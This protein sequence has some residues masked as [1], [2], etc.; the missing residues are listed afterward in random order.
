MR[1]ALILATKSSDL[2]QVRT[3]VAKPQQQAEIDCCSRALT[4][5]LGAVLLFQM[6]AH[7]FG[8]VQ[9]PFKVKA[10]QHITGVRS[11]QRRKGRHRRDVSGL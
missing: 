1:R 5:D 2:R 8:S 11:D 4:R 3:F 6:D 10:G 7:A 9:Q